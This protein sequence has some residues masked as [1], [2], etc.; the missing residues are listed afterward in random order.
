VRESDGG[1]QRCGFR[2]IRSRLEAS[3]GAS[4]GHQQRH[5]RTVVAAMADGNKVVR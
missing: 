4:D 1:K 5:E 3:N 2:S